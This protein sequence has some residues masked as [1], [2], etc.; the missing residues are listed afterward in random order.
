M[1]T[2]NTTSVAAA[3]L[4]VWALTANLSAQRAV[5]RGGSSGGG[6]TSSGGHSSGGS[7]GS[8]GSTSG[9]SSGGQRSGGAVQRAPARGDDSPAKGGTVVAR[10]PEPASGNTRDTV[11]STPARSDDD[12]NESAPASRGRQGTGSYGKAV[13]R[14][15][16]PPPTDVDISVPGGYYGGY[17]PWGWSGIGFG[18]YY[19]GYYDPWYYGGGYPT[20]SGSYNDYDAMLRLKMKPREAQVFADGYF[21]GVVD[22]F[23]GMWQRLHLQPGPHRIEVRGEG[24]ETLMFEVNLQPDKTITYTGELRPV[25]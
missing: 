5:P 16:A 14:K 8:G 10:T 17:Y 1:R 11:A 4:C 7:S 3:L 18:G 2:R 13:P 12:N 9:G 21:M 24:Y 19:G 6:S 23:D 25:Q 22:D 15:G 20:Y